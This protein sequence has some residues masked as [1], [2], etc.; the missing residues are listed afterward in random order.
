MLNKIVV[1]IMNKIVV[2]NMSTWQYGYDLF[3]LWIDQWLNALLGRNYF[4]FIF[5][6][7]VLET[8]LSD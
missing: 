1:C 8:S 6:G 7:C 4:Y 5:D 3:T 2:Y